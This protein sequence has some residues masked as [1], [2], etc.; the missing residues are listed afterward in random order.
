MELILFY[1][2]GKELDI[3]L[4]SSTLSQIRNWPFILLKID[5]AI[6]SDF[7]NVPGV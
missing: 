2:K 5:I 7:I 1:L 4:T 6:N 3:S